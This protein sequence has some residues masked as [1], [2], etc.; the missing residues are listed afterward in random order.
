MKRLIRPATILIISLL[1]IVFSVG[2]SQSAILAQSAKVGSNSGAAL[3]FQT[4]GT[5]QPKE[6]RSEIGSTDGITA[7]SFVIVAIVIIPIFWLRKSWSQSSS[8]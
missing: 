2:F 8:N 6:D 3:F 7:M 5:P 1:L 4:T